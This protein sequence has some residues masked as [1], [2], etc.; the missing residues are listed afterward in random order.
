MNKKNSPA[1]Y[2]WNEISSHIKAGRFTDHILIIIALHQ[3]EN[4]KTN[5]NRFSNKPWKYTGCI[6]K[7][8]HIYEQK[9]Q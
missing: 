5:L 2:E 6:I 3:I 1:L 8:V 7:P 9:H 4:S